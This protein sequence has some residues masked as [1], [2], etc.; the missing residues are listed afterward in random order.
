[1]TFLHGHHLE[2]IVFNAEFRSVMAVHLELIIT[3]FVGAELLTGTI[4]SMLEV[5]TIAT[6]PVHEKHIAT[7][8]VR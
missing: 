2:R 1:M 8:G 5:G 7:P 3:Q 4:K 6:P